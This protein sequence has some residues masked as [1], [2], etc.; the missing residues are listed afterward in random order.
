LPEIT[1]LPNGVTVSCASGDRVFD[2]A[3]QHGVD[4]D[5]A[6]VGMGNC[7]L[8]RV[9]IV[10]G[11]ELLNAYTEAE[12]RHLGNVYHLTQVRLSCQIRVGE[13]NLVVDVVR[14]R[15]QRKP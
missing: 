8:C 5:T 6:C 3:R 15:A 10:S 7:G 2:V 4:I 13:G 12:Y 11:A 9:R 1:F 14:Q